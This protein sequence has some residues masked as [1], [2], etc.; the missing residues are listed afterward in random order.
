MN[1]TNFSLGLQQ[2]P[3]KYIDINQLTDIQQIICYLI[4][5]NLSNEAI[6]KLIH[7]LNY[8]VYKNISKKSIER[9]LEILKQKFAVHSKVELIDL[10]IKNHYYRYIPKII[11]DGLAN[12]NS[13]L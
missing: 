9:H 4:L 1:R 12:N 2:F 10:L 5:Y 13:T 6:T 3:N 7:H 8:G 11:V